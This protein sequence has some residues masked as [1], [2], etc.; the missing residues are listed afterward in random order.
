M[1]DTAQA[2]LFIATEEHPG[3]TVGAKGVD[4][5]D[6]TIGA[7][8]GH[9]VFAEHPQA[10]RPPIRFRQ[11]LCQQHRVPEAAEQLAHRC[12]RTGSSKEFVV[13][14]AE[15]STPPIMQLSFRSAYQS[16]T[17]GSLIE[18]AARSRVTNLLLWPRRLKD[19]RESAPAPSQGLNEL[20]GCH[21]PPRQDADCRS[22]SIQRRGLLDNDL[23]VC[24]DA[25]TV[26][27]EGQG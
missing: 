26:A 23:E 9:Q 1:V 8:E 17:G 16:D 3:S 25:P 20:H 10:H 19:R 24:G 27:I 21:H 14:Q 11:F 5:A 22:F 13:A 7:S 18:E 12:P 15:H 6:L 4:D 2:A